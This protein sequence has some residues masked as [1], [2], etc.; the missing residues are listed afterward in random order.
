MEPTVAR[1]RVLY[2]RRACVMG[3]VIHVASSFGFFLLLWV[4]SMYTRYTR[5]IHDRCLYQ[6][7]YGDSVRGT[8]RAMQACFTHTPLFRGEAKR[9]INVVNLFIYIS[10]RETGT[11][12]SSLYGS[13][14]DVGVRSV[15]LSSLASSTSS[16]IYR[17]YLNLSPHC[18][19]QDDR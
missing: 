15:T 14:A 8:A 19:L 17:S 9:S 12:S 7:L 2:A 10:A 5:V 1:G 16:L 13:S 4:R 6:R 18:A 3:V 11:W